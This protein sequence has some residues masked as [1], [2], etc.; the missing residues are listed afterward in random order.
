MD[1]SLF[2]KEL[3]RVTDLGVCEVAGAGAECSLF[4]PRPPLLLNGYW[5]LFLGPLFFGSTKLHQ[6]D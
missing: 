1:V 4:P 3:T 2:W 5:E 6:G